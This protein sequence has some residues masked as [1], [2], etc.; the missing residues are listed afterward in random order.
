MPNYDAREFHKLIDDFSFLIKRL[1]PVL[2]KFKDDMTKYLITKQDIN[3]SYKELPEF[4]ERY[5]T[6]N[7]ST[8]AREDEFVFTN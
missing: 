3:T 5:E 8:Y 4:L 2:T 1:V 6:M 7:L